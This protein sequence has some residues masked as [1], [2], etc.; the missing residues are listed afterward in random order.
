MVEQTQGRETRGPIGVLLIG[1][2]NTASSLLEAARSV[3]GESHFTDV[4]ALDAGVGTSAAFEARVD[5]ELQRLDA[6]RGVLVLAD[7]M[8]S[9]PCNCG[10]KELVEHRGGVLVTGLS[11]AML[12]KLATS[13][14][15]HARAG[16]LAE[17]LAESARRAVRVS[18]EAPP[19]SRPPGE[20]GASTARGTEGAAPEAKP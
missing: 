18:R 9:S 8:G 14:R 19:I 7:L 15:T 4:V 12:C 1:H 17:A 3:I 11:L 5:A 13:D 20:G 10:R 6:G 2:G 16:D